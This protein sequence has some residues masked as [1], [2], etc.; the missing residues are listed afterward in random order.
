LTQPGDPGRGMGGDQPGRTPGG[1]AM[2]GFVELGTCRNDPC[3]QCAPLLPGG[4]CSDDCRREA[5]GCSVP[6]C[7]CGGAC[8]GVSQCTSCE[9]YTR[10]VITGGCPDCRKASVGARP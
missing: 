5:T 10:D 6:D 1:M 4:F 7:G 3:G 2:N 8:D 9:R